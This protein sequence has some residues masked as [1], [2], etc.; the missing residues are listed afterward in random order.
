[1]INQLLPTTYQLPDYCRVNF[2]AEL[3]ANKTVKLIYNGQVLN[4]ELQTLTQL[5]L[6][7]NC[8]VHCLIHQLRTSGN[9]A[10]GSQETST[11]S[12]PQVNPTQQVPQPQRSNGSGPAEAGVDIGGLLV[13]LFAVILGLVWYCRI[14]YATHFTAAATTALVGLSGICILF[15]FAVWHPTLTVDPSP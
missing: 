7:N 3:S 12:S 1:M 11:P 15:V 8:V 9:T 14:A 4:S 13:P 10:P 2:R 6:D 5:G